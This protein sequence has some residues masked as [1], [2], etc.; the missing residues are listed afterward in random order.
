MFLLENELSKEKS[1]CHN[2]KQR[3]T[4]LSEGLA[5][6]NFKIEK[7]IFVLE[8]SKEIKLMELEL[9]SYKEAYNYINTYCQNLKNS[10]ISIEKINYN[11]LDE[12]SNLK[13]YIREKNKEFYN[14]KV[15]L[16]NVKDI[17]EAEKSYRPQNKSNECEI[18]EGKN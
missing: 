13:Q 1:L 12:N 8:P 7:E 16:T 2:F 3:Y 11:L 10:L 14:Q 4:S 5:K 6:K 18:K 17:V 15:I 9:N